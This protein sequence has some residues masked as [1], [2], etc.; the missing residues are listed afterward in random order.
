MSWNPFK[1]NTSDWFDSEWMFGVDKFNIILGNP[2]YIGHKG[3][4]KQ[5]FRK[6]K[7]TALGKSFNNER[8]DIFY[9]FFH[10]AINNCFEEG[11][12]AFI[13]TN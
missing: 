1:D 3:G 11:V 2:P 8:M 12:I 7:T 5:L 6:L 10:K 4:Q 13:T 9:Y